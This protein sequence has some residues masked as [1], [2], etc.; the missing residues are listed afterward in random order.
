[1][2]QSHRRSKM[3][4]NNKDSGHDNSAQLPKRMNNNINRKMREP[5]TSNRDSS[6]SPR[7]MVGRN[8]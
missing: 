4:D 5:S 7:R 6:S 1:M 8:T 3:M 2:R